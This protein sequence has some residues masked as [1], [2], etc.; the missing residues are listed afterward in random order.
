MSRQLRIGS[1]DG[2][3]SI[4]A[5]NKTSTSS[6]DN[7]IEVVAVSDRRQQKMFLRLP[8]KLYQ[9]DPHWT[10]PLRHRQKQLVN[11]SR[12][13]F[14]E[15][16]EAQTFLAFKNGEVV[17]R[18]AAIV[19]HAHNRHYDENRGMFGFFESIQDENVAHA[20]LDAAREWHNANGR[21]V[22]R[23][24]VNPSM[25]YECGLLVEGF[26]S[27]ATFMMTYNPDYYPE[28]FDS[29]GM[30]KAQDL[31]AYYGHVD[32]MSNLDP[33]LEFVAEEAAKRFNIKVRPLNPKN[34]EHE[35]KTFMDIYNSAVLGNWGFVPMSKSEL[36][37]VGKGLQN[38]IVPEL[39][40]IG[41]VDGK[42]VGIV[43]GL[44]DYN[45]LIKK[46]D[47]KLFPFGFLRILFQK[48]TVHRARMVSTNIT[49]EFQRWG[50]VIVLLRD[51]G[52]RAIPWGIEDAEFSWVLETNKLSRG[53]LERGGAKKIKTYR[54]YDLDWA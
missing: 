54:I 15:N 33:K 10:P 30:E 50:L 17:G 35:I 3:L 16:A 9:N 18:V 5:S 44:L 14:Y 52:S 12:H 11:Y 37:E 41:E 26:D 40:A 8:W 29:F 23:G 28:Y 1:G 7:S 19:D 32:M 47:G 2:S 31:F 51:L 6:A 38:L 36:V 20:L 22:M 13:P 4:K 27:P 45:P 49:P 46:M 53:S 42:S 43:F 24:P 48:K 39:T 34:F 25:N 21:K